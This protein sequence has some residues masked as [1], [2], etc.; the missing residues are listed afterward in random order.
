[1]YVD[2]LS[3]MLNMQ[4]SGCYIGDRKVNHLMYA[5]DIVVLAPSARALQALLDTC[6]NFGNCNGAC[7]NASKSVVMVCRSKLLKDVKIPY[8]HLDGA[9]LNEVTEVKYLGHVIRN[10]LSDDDDILRA[11][12]QLYCQGNVLLRSFHMCTMDVKPRLFRT[13]C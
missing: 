13:Y 9:K 5:D 7:Y 1:M 10:D 2:E 4:R 12:R 3:V 6:T 11:T 8:F